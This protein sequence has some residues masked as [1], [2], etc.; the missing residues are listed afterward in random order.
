MGGFKLIPNVD[1]LIDQLQSVKKLAKIPNGS[2][3]AIE[4]TKLT[5]E[6][7]V[8]ETFFNK[9]IYI[10]ES[11]ESLNLLI[12]TALEL[13]GYDVQNEIDIKSA[14][15]PSIIIMDSGDNLSK[16]DFL[17]TIKKINTFADTKVIVTTNIHSKSEILNSGADLYLPKPYEISE[18]IQ[19][20][21]YF[22][23][24]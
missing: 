17:R 3:Y 1:V 12:R 8:I 16:L 19:W 20:V 11:D 18:L 23:S 5:A 22:L 21:E 6:N 7:S 4:R 14:E 15:Q 10:K 9:N 13:Q 24:K 2:N